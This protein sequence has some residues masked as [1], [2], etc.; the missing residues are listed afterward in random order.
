MN[1]PNIF[2][3]VAKAVRAGIASYGNAEEV[4]QPQAAA[5]LP[6]LPMPQAPSGQTSL[7]S[8]RTETERSTE[9]LTKTNR[10]TANT[11]ATTFRTGSV[12]S[13]VIRNFLAANP[14]MS[15]TVNAYLR[16]GI[17]KG[18]RVTGHDLDGLINADATKL[19]HELLTRMTYLSDPT[20]GYNPTTDLQSLSEALGR[21]LLLEG[22]CALELVLD[23]MGLPTY[24]QPVA[25]STLQFREDTDKGIY[26][27]QVIG[28]EEFEL[29]IPTM[30]YLSVDQD[31][32]TPYSVAFLGAAV[33]AVLA[34]EGFANFLQRQLKRNIA[35]RMV[36]TIIEDKLKKSVDPRVLN[37]PKKFQ[38]YI[39]AVIAS[40]TTTLEDLEPEEALI[41]T[42]AI[43]YKLKT[44]EGG[45]SGVGDMMSSLKSIFQERLTAALKSL[46]AVL[47]RDSSSGSATT[48]TYLFLK[49]AEMISTKLNTLYSRM[50]T[51]A[52]RLQGMDC[53]VK[54]EYDELD[55]RPK[56][57]QEA[58]LQ[59]R[60]SRVLDLYSLGFYTLQET[61]VRLTGNLPPEGCPDLS[62]TMFRQNKATVQDTTS[63]TSLMNGQKDD[64]KSDAPTGAK[65][66]NK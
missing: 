43:D 62:G 64:L 38:E 53:Y 18:F 24:P 15:A 52:V 16:V 37:D 65:G 26:P 9:L 55:L 29:D 34:D 45:G 42:D 6:A 41:A 54:F 12:M 66:E 27:V 40:I 32:L 3:K 13:D 36:A 58:Y 20:A 46:P 33:R 28:G 35:P 59:M 7:P 5:T 39:N 60:Q 50:L 1:K 4:A 56:G 47:G 61:S 25:V 14:D 31:L 8:Y 51:L 10:I 19:A 11:D 17:P 30:F 23:S 49:S 2:S 63:Q 44:P 21:E 22:G 48:S 57:E